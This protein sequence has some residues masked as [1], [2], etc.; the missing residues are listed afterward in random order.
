[1]F[2]SPGYSH[3][4]RGYYDAEGHGKGPV[5]YGRWVGDDPNT[6]WSVALLSEPG[7]QYSPPGAFG[8]PDVAV[9]V[10]QTQIKVSTTTRPAS[11][12]ITDWGA[13]FPCGDRVC[14]TA[15]RACV[16]PGGEMPHPQAECTVACFTRVVT[17]RRRRGE[18][19]SLV[20]LGCWL[21]LAGLVG[22]RVLP[23]ASRVL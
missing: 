17:R 9:L 8:Q 12:C 2:V 16:F 7:N 4:P 3:R 1:M 18:F 13:F 11:T 21:L 10:P 5:D 6:W 15:I 23:H 20:L 14:T 22:D 19:V